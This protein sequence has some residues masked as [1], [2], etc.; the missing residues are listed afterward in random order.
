LAEHPEL[1][2]LDFTYAWRAAGHLLAG[3][4]PYDSMPAA[5]YTEGG[6][7]LYPLTTAMLVSPLANLSA[8]SAGAIFIGVSSALLAAGLTWWGD[9]WRLLVFL[10]PAWL[11]AF[12]NIQWSPLL[13]AS[14]LLPA[15]GWVAVAKPNLGLIAFAYRPR[16]STVIA[17]GALAAVSL[18]WM[19]GWPASW[20]A[21]LKMQEAPHQP[22]ILWP[23]GF[24]GLAA[25]LRWRTREGRALV[26]ASVAPAMS[27]PYDHLLL[28]LVAR[29]WRESL[30]LV[31]T[32]WIA[33]L[34]ALA[35]APHD[36]TRSPGFVQAL[37]AVGMYLPA[38]IIVLRREN[39][40]TVPSWVDRVA[41]RWPGWLR[42]ISA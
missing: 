20:L 22:P 10:S 40:G 2:A 34:V 17:C 14:A 25:L 3:R 16:W 19:P 1:R 21:A 8:A 37:L 13:M 24:V 15:L 9:Y 35:T 39:A 41:E 6:L 23:F 7:F 36:L 42:G 5:P 38:T 27:L 30:I 28:W 12:F 33:W 4:N 32:S 11:L 29:N 26:A 31:A 18:V